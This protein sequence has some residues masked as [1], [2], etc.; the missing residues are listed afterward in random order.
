MTII[1]IVA[2]DTAD[3]KIVWANE[4]LDFGEGVRSSD[5]MIVDKDLF[6]G[7][8]QTDGDLCVYMTLAAQLHLGKERTTL[9]VD[10][11]A[12]I[13]RV[14]FKNVAES[15]RKD[16]KTA[17]LS[18][19]KVRELLNERQPESKKIFALSEYLSEGE[20]L[21]KASVRMMKEGFLPSFILQ[22]EDHAV[23]G[24]GYSSDEKEIVV[25]DSLSG[26]GDPR[27]RRIPIDRNDLNF[28]SAVELDGNFK[29]KNS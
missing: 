11:K 1:R 2:E 29:V 7:Q 28:V 15:L 26:K 5:K 10:R 16:V 17:R 6:R 27:L 3:K 22:N 20:T 9:S 14:G 13:E 25:W 12:I 18:N 19:W 23:L 21:G 8:F 24:I 4:P